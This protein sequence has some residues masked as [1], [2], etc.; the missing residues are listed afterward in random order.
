[1]IKIFKKNSSLKK[2]NTFGID[3]KT[4]YFAEYSTI[5][6]LQEILKSDIVKSNPL[7][8]IGSGSNLLFINDFKGVVL[9][10]I[11]QSIE[12]LEE[13]EETILIKVGAGVV[14]DDFVQYCVKNNFIGVENLSLIPGE[15][16]ASAVQNIGAYGV[17]VKDVIQNVETIDTKTLQLKQFSNEE[18]QYEYRSSVFKTEQKNRYIVTHVTFK[19]SKKEDFTLHYSHLKESVLELGEITL[20][21]IRKTVIKIRESKLPDPKELGNAGSFFMNPIITK[22][23]LKTIQINYP[24]IPSYFLNNNKVKIPAGWLI[25]QAG[26][27][28]KRFG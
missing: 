25:E 22:E 27:K 8:H 24:N 7:L 18:C 23:Q 3:V 12:I 26:L 14:W 5:S 2:Y 1:M 6:E 19:L 15:V 4:N 9:H 17:E 28:G 11:I 16:G 10:S 13:N 21:N 20:G